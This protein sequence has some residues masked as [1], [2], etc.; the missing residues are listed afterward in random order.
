MEK[1]VERFGPRYRSIA[2]WPLTGEIGSREVVSHAR[3]RRA[4]PGMLKAAFRRCH[5]FIHGNEGM[6]KGAA[7]WQFLYVLFTKMYDEREA[8]RGG[9]NRFYAGLHEP[10]TTEGQ[11][12]IAGRIRALFDEVKAEYP[13]FTTRDELTMSDRA[14]AFLVGEMAPYD[15]TNSGID[16]KGLAVDLMVKILDPQEHEP[17]V[18]HRRVPARHAA[19]PVGELARGGGH[20]GAAGH[21]REVRGAPPPAGALRP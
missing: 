4:D 19:A 20:D 3:L 13:L 5:N 9:G 21:R 7:F 14:L 15:F 1:T 18:G 12:E 17:R 10:F 16:V 11:R 2:D 8:L 6:P